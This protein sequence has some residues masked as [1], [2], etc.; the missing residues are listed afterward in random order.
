MICID[1]DQA[2]RGSYVVVAYGESMSAAREDSY[3][4]PPRSPECLPRGRHKPSFRRLLD[5]EHDRQGRRR[6]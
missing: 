4:H 6:R 1:C 3:A 5:E 2:I